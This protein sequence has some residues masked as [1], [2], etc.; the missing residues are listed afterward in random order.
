MG[1]LSSVGIPPPPPDPRKARESKADLE[2]MNQAIAMMA[3]MNKM[4]WHATKDLLEAMIDT[5]E[6]RLVVAEN[7]RTTAEGVDALDELTIYIVTSP[8]E[9]APPKT[10]SAPPR[11]P[12]AIGDRRSRSR[13][14]RSRDRRSRSRGV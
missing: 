5:V 14:R 7:F 13:D 9:K 10:I 6:H 3:S 8:W 12:L 11:K 2:R 4:D 1:V